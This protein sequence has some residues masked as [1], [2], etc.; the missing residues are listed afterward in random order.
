[1]ASSIVRAMDDEGKLRR[2]KCV[3]GLVL[4][5][6][7]SYGQGVPRERKVQ[8]VCRYVCV[9]ACVCALCVHALCVHALCVRV[10]V[11]VFAY[12]CNIRT[13]SWGHI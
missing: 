6:C 8:R 1:L 4:L 9:C 7:E 10:C 11:C 3:K 12:E 2:V 13:Y 5:R